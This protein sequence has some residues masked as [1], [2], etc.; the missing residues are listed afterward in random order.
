[1]GP[2]THHKSLNGLRVKKAKGLFTMTSLYFSEFSTI[3]STKKTKKNQK[4][5]LH[6][7]YFVDSV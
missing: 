4:K 2:R 5:K 3:S 6:F 1:M 7:D